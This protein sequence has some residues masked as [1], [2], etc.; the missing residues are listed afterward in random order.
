MATATWIKNALEQ[1]GIPFEEIPHREVFTA[2]EVAQSEHVS[3]HRLAKVVVI[4]ADGRPYEL[5]VPASRRVVLE[6]LGPMLGAREVRL[7]SEAEMDRIFG[8]IETG[9]IPAL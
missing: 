6:K 5:V 8:D 1:R 3:G 9:A 7:A 2:Q 4:M